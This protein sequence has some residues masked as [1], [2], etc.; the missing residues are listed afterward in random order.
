MYTIEGKNSK[1]VRTE[2]YNKKR[3][4]YIQVH[5]MYGEKVDIEIGLISMQW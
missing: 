1:I 3:K 2:K 4:C 5:Y